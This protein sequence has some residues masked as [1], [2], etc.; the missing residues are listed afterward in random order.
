VPLPPPRRSA[1][2]KPDLNAGRIAGV[3][4]LR[5]ELKLDA[6]RVGDDALRVG[7]AA[8]LRLADGTTREVTIA[9][10]RRQKDRPLIRIAGIAD[11]NAAQAVVG[12][13]VTIARDDAPLREQEYFDEDLIGCRLIDDAGVERGVVVDVLHYPHQDMLVVGAARALLPLIR[14]FVAGVDLAR[15]EIRVTVP[16]GLLDPAAADEA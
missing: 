5:G 1:K 9:S 16:A 10:V 2:R 13:S 15:K 3:F 14:A 7:L 11:A 12:A 6:S 8:T 4:G